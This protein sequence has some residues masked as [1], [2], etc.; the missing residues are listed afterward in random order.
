AGLPLVTLSACR[1]AEVGPLVGTEV[2]GLVTGLLGGGARAVVA[3]LWPVAD[4]ESL[5]LMAGF[6]RHRLTPDLPAPLALAPREALAPPAPLPGRPWPGAGAPPA[7]RRRA[8]LGAGWAAA[9][10]AGTPRA[11]RCRTGRRRRP[12]G[13]HR[14]DLPPA[15]LTAGPRAAASDRGC[16]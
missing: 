9:D 12:N 2:F 3:G 5:P 11:C 6:Y 13:L 14:A 10:S 1:A 4:A 8:R 7:C 16:C 15:T